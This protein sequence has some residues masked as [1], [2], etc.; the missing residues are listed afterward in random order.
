MKN[1]RCILVASRSSGSVGKSL[2]ASAIGI[3]LKRMEI[4]TSYFKFYPQ[5]EED[6]SSFTPDEK[7]GCFIL[8]NGMITA[9]DIGL[10]ESFVGITMESQSY[11]TLANL[12]C[13][14]IPDDS[15]IILELGKNIND[16]IND[17][18]ITR[19]NK[20]KIDFN[21]FA[22]IF[23]DFEVQNFSKLA[24]DI[25]IY[26]NS[27]DEGIY[28]PFYDDPI[29]VIE[30]LIKNQKFVDFIDKFI[31][32][33]DGYNELSVYLPNNLLSL[34]EYRDFS[35]ELPTDRSVSK[36]KGPEDLNTN[37]HLDSEKRLFINPIGKNSNY[38]NIL[39]I[40]KYNKHED[41][42]AIIKNA[43]FFS[44]RI[45]NIKVNI[46]ILNPLNLENSYEECE[47]QIGNPDGIIF[48]GGSGCEG[49]EGLILAIKYARV[50]NIP[51]LAICLGYQLSV[52]EFA[53]SVLN[54][55]EATS[56]E[57]T[58]NGNFHIIKKID[59]FLYGEV[60]KGENMVVLDIKSKT[61]DLYFSY[62]D[63]P[64]IYDFKADLNPKN[65][66]EFVGNVEN[67]NYAD[68]QD[69]N[70]PTEICDHS[71]LLNGAVIYSEA[72]G[73]NS[74]DVNSHF[75]I[76]SCEENADRRRKCYE[77]S[78]LKHRGIVYERHRHSFNVC[79][80]YVDLLE[81]C[82]M[83]F[84]ARDQTGLIMEAFE[85]E[86][87]PFFIGVQFHPEV[88]ASLEFPHPL[89]T[90]FLDQSQKNQFKI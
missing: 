18:I 38:K 84:T 4:K 55:N 56:A 36:Y 67:Y 89:F 49:T 73:K 32:K 5:H 58:D 85:L 28:L 24:P 76:E 57:F 77:K 22:T 81:S 29:D 20:I 8:K 19:I 42:Y 23:I 44:A 3:I 82:G 11:V 6:E 26:R 43:I 86:N 88:S 83:K 12:N 25:V 48:S 13:F 37:H 66:S 2:V 21:K 31:L 60:R 79:E 50:N 10:F 53:R 70:L 90:A 27:H 16:N 39:I 14:S 51:T 62:E 46:Q 41:K 33:P 65:T 30:N 47:K 54:I 34:N 7:G 80:N 71:G 87:H 1:S 75:Q 15:F 64:V 40:G 9:K 69:K 52:I 35:S 61:Y 68:S 59:Q 17:S 74:A 63:C 78:T 72:Y 45:L